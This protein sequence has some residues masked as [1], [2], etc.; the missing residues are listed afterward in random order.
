MRVIVLVVLGRLQAFL[1]RMAEANQRLKEQME[2]APAGHFD[3]ERVDEAG[4][5]IE[6]VG[7]DGGGARPGGANCHGN[8]LSP[9]RRQD[10]ALVELSGS[11]SDFGG[12]EEESSASEDEEE[13][14]TLRLPGDKAK[15][16]KANIQVVGE[17]GEP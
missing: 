9:R 15:K 5:V 2:A 10:V 11:E 13:E 7:G 4:R 8:A 6:M 3:I 17:Q 1:P 14:E 12:G 16:Q